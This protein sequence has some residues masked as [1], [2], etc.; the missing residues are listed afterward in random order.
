[1]DDWT[2]EQHAF[3]LA[4]TDAYWLDQC[5]FWARVWSSPTL[6]NPRSAAVHITDLAIR[7]LALEAL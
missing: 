7:R 5:I 2:P 6:F 4:K 1:M 3:W